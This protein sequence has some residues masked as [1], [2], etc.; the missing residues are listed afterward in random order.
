M[1]H[2]TDEMTELYELFTKQQCH[3]TSHPVV[4]S[5]S[6]PENITEAGQTIQSEDAWTTKIVQ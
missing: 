2:L 1:K 6:R 5:S 3:V 4:W